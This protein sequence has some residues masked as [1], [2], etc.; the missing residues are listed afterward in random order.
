MTGHNIKKLKRE[1]RRGNK[2]QTKVAGIMAPRLRVCA[3]LTEYPLGVAHCH[4]P[5]NLRFWGSYALRW[6]TKA[7]HTNAYFHT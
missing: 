6:T 5:C 7:I 3:V 1:E 4:L 2:K